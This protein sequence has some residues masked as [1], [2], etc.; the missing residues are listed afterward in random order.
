M[1]WLERPPEM[2]VAYIAGPLTA[3]IWFDSVRNVIRAAHVARKYYLMGYAVHCPHLNTAFHWFLR[4]PMPSYSDYLNGDMA[5]LRRCDAVVMMHNWQKSP[6]ACRE[7]ELAKR[8][9]KEI[10]YE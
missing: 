2:R 4:G 5:I 6:G 7:W 3:H 8:L 1:P 9:N 10:L